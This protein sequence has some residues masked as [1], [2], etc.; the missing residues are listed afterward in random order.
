MKT[1]EK[2]RYKVSL[3]EENTDFTFKKK[4][5]LRRGEENDREQEPVVARPPVQLLVLDKDEAK[6]SLMPLFVE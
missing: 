5:K 3:L 4:L 2:A 1:V 6:S